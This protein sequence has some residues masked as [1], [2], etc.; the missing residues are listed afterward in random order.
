M[1]I[2]NLKIAAAIIMNTSGE[3]LLVRKHGTT[4][5]MQPGGKIDANETPTTALC[6][7]LN[8]ELGLTVL[9]GELVYAGNY[10]AIAANEPDTEVDAELFWF[11]FGGVMH[12]G[13]E[14]AEARWVYPDKPA[15]ELA[16]LTRDA[17]L[18]L[19]ADYVRH[20]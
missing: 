13:A 12:I 5:F 7:E 20:A 11:R 2:T 17:A 16:P 18:P 15:V 10:R 1:P 4:A 8:E 19:A 9:P 14:I 6:R 3:T